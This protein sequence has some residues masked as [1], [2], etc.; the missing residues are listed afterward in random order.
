MLSLQKGDVV[1]A[2]NDTKILTTHDLERAT[3]V[4]HDFWKI[5]ISRGDQII[6]TVVGG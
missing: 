2:V 1:L 6:T 3:S 4:Q 5:S